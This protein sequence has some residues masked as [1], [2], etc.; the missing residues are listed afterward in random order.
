MALIGPR[1]SAPTAFRHPRNL[2]ETIVNF[3]GATK[4]WLLITVMIP[5]AAGYVGAGQAVFM[6]TAIAKPLEKL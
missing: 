5:A 2:T 6:S 3:R 1:R 4:S